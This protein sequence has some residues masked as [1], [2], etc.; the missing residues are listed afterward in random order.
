MSKVLDQITYKLLV[1]E[2]CPSFI[3]KLFSI[4]ISFLFISI[5]S[6][7]GAP[8]H[9]LPPQTSTLLPRLILEKA[10][11]TLIRGNMVLS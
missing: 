5:N 9:P 4:A 10:Y 7:I 1:F 2:V 11:S 8:H 6:G 3:V